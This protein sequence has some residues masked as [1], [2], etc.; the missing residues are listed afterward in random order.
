MLEVITYRRR[1]HGGNVYSAR[2][3]EVVPRLSGR[4]EGEVDFQVNIWEGH[5]LQRVFLRLKTWME[6][7]ES[8]FGSTCQHELPVT[9]YSL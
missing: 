6:M 5:A 7:R 8:A 9:F 1:S 2:I 4:T 3:Q